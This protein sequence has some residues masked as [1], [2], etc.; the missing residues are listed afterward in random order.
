MLFDSNLRL[1]DERFWFQYLCYCL[2]FLRERLRKAW[3]ANRAGSNFDR[4][5]LKF[6]FLLDEFL[7]EGKSW[8]WCNYSWGSYYFF[9]GDWG[10][11]KIW[12]LD[13]LW[14]C[15]YLLLSNN[16]GCWLDKSSRWL[17]YFCWCRSLIDLSRCL[18]DRSSNSCGINWLTILLLQSSNL[19]SLSNKSGLNISIR[20]SI[21]SCC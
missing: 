2:D 11:H 14:G 4:F 13:C 8:G 21:S 7:L 20:S 9:L 18:C 12:S 1:N 3:S 10:N 19:L 5:D 17:S 16:W 6:L 15:N